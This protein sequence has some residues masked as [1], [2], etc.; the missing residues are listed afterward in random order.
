VP[1]KALQQ[2]EIKNAD[3]G[4]FSAVFSTFNVVDSDGDVTHPGAFEDGAEALVSSYGH[5]SWAGAL[6]VGKGRIRQTAGGS[7][8]SSD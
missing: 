3:R 2:V 1:D 7:A 5:Q 4:E 6:P 8:T